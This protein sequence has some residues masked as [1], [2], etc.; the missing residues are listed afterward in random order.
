MHK[1]QWSILIVSVGFNSWSAVMV[2]FMLLRTV[3]PALKL[4][5]VHYEWK[6]TVHADKCNRKFLFATTSF[7]VKLAY[8]I[9]SCEEPAW[10]LLSKGNFF[11]SIHAYCRIAQFTYVKSRCVNFRCTVSL[12]HDCVNGTWQIVHT[13]LQLHALMRTHIGKKRQALHKDEI[14]CMCFICCLEKN[15]LLGPHRFFVQ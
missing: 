8:D 11:S 9:P 2:R 13:L 6:N 10:W 4:H 5:V 14:D 1:L 15:S 3:A 12:K 7:S